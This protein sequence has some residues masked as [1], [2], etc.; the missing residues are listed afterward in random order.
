MTFPTLVSLIA[1]TFPPSSIQAQPT[2]KPVPAP[3]PSIEEVIARALQTHPEILVAEAKLAGAKAELE[4]AKLAL[5]QKI[6]KAKNRYD[7]AKQTEVHAERAL[8][9]ILALYETKAVSTE[10]FE[11]TREKAELAK[12]QRIEAEAEWKAVQPA[13][14]LPMTIDSIWYYDSKVTAR[15]LAEPSQA[16][17]DRYELLMRPLKM[18]KGEKIDL[19]EAAKLLQGNPEFKSLSLRVPAWSS[20]TVLKSAPLIEMTDGEMSVGGW[21][22]F[23]AYEFNAGT[24]EDSNKAGPYDWYVREYGLVFEKV[25]NKPVGAPSLAEFLKAM[26]AAPAQKE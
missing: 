16:E 2:P 7:T 5:S 24:F 20:R 22:L 9:R 15:P 13:A 10:Q 4:L 19:V 26:R 23:I 6:A 8:A 17:R 12:T 11:L 1:L 25:A 14:K 21:L 18:K 3:V